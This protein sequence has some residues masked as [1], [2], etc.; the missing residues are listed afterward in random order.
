MQVKCLKPEA[1][2]QGRKE[3]SQRRGAKFTPP[4]FSLHVYLYEIFR[5]GK[6]IET[7]SRLVVAG[8]WGGGQRVAAHGCRVSLGRGW[9]CSFWS[10][11]VVKVAQ[12]CECT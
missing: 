4:K 3:E 8:D 7:E 9:Q 1:E 10:W 12:R 6:S 5:R 2:F 11:I